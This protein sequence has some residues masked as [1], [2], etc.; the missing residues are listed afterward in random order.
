MFNPIFQRRGYYDPSVRMAAEEAQSAQ[1]DARE[2]QSQVESLRS[3]VE[4]LLIISEALWTLLKK[5]HGYTDEVLSNL[6]T[7][8]DLRDGHLDG[9]APKT[10]PLPCPNCG[11]LHSGRR[12]FC[13]YCGK[14]VP[15]QPFTR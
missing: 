12:P 14:P 7:E 5:Q 1:R 15:I 4:R 2:A 3:E 6:V 10:A 13:I 8:I 11:K 9:R